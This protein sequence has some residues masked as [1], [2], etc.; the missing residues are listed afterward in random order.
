V[1]NALVSVPALLVLLA[2][3]D[4]RGVIAIAI[5]SGPFPPIIDRVVRATVSRRMGRV[6]PMVTLVGALVGV[7]IA[8]VAGLILGPVALAM[9]F[10]LLEIYDKEQLTGQPL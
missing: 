6:H 5:F 4:Y 2:R 7:G 8:G 3:Q 9:F 10:V 1:G